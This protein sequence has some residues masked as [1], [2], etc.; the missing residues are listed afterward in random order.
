MATLA[1]QPAYL[2]ELEHDANSVKTLVYE[3]VIEVLSSVARARSLRQLRATVTKAVPAYLPL[4]HLIMDSLPEQPAPSGWTGGKLTGAINQ[5]V[6]NALVDGSLVLS[7]SDRDVVLRTLKLQANMEEIESRGQGEWK[8]AFVAAFIEAYWP[9]Q[10]LDVC[11][12]TLYLAARGRIR[13]FEPRIPHWLCLIARDQMN[14]IDGAL[15]RNNPV[16][17][18]RLREP[19]PTISTAELKK[20]LG[21]SG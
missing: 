12:S 11:I 10:E 6:L 15:F 5:Q 19:A 16:L 3:H 1:V 13:D 17:H 9:M 4:K 20:S 8:V 14:A 18:R 21:L 7:R 2:D